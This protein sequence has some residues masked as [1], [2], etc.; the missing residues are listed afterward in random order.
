MRMAVPAGTTNCSNTVLTNYNGAAWTNAA[1]STDL[2]VTG[3]NNYV[4]AGSSDAFN[5]M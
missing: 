3:F 5:Y 4:A 1:C 2:S